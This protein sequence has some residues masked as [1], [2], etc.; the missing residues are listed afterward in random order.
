[1]LQNQFYMVR[2]WYVNPNTSWTG[3]ARLNVSRKYIH[4][5]QCWRAGPYNH[6]SI[7]CEI[8]H[9]WSWMSWTHLS[10]VLTCGSGGLQKRV[11]F[12]MSAF[13]W[14][15]FYSILQYWTVFGTSLALS[16]TVED[17]TSSQLKH[18]QMQNFIK[19]NI[20]AGTFLCVV[21]ARCHFH[22]FVKTLFSG[23]VFN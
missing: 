16:Q 11:F 14:H 5:F 12:K 23:S 10:T 15:T 8:T 7:S 22:I 17:K 18:Y 6:L 21:T 20:F 4:S 1:M 13:L 2:V 19:L 3:C 9:I